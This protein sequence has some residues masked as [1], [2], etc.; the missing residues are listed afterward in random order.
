MTIAAIA[1]AIATIA[2][3]TTVTIS[4]VTL[5]VTGIDP[6]PAQLSTAQLPAAYVLAGDGTIEWGSDYGIETRDYKLQCAVEGLEQSTRE[7]KEAWIRALIVA[8][9][10]KLAGYPN[11]G[12]AGVQNA[13]VTGDTGALE[14]QDSPSKSYVG[15]EMTINVTELIARTY[16]TGE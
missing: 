9:R 11:L 14:I 8:M 6:P 2:N 13:L 10:D 7:T 16:A 4:G 15:F 1:S 3:G 12:A 5:T